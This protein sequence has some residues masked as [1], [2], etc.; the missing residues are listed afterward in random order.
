[1]MLMTHSKK[2]I[3]P[4]HMIIVSDALIA[5]QKNIWVTGFLATGCQ[6]AMVKADSSEKS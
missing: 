4:S 1:M 3:F 2:K 5:V 6:T